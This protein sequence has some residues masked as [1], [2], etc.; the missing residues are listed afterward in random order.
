MKFDAVEWGSGLGTAHGILMDLDSGMGQALVHVAEVTTAGGAGEQLSPTG[1]TI[2]VDASKLRPSKLR[3]VGE[4][5][6]GPELA[7]DLS[8]DPDAGT[9]DSF[10]E[11]IQRQLRRWGGGFD[12]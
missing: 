5:P 7:D 12:G 1:K 2:K 11:K 8:D 4:E 10:Y 9:D 3:P 6:V